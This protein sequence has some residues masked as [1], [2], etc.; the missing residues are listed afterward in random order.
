MPRAHGSRRIPAV[1]AGILFIY[2]PSGLAAPQ[3]PA[4]WASLFDEH[5]WAECRREALRAAPED[6]RAAVM[7]DI[8]LLRLRAP[9][10]SGALGRLQSVAQ[11]EQHPAAPTAALEVGRHHLQ[12]QRTV[13]AWPWFAQA[14]VSTNDPDEF[15]EAGSALA[16]IGMRHRE[17]LRSNPSLADQLASGRMLWTPDRLRAIAPGS[18]SGG[19]FARLARWPAR[20]IVGL[21]RS[22]IRPAIGSRCNLEPGC[23]AYFLEASRRHGLTG[24]PM[25]A[26]R[27]VREPGVNARGE[28]P[29]SMPS[30]TI[31][32][33]DPIEDHDFW[34][35]AKDPP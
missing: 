3:P 29:V 4:L 13:E 21:Y 30:G 17:L 19:L 23:S 10:A 27:L 28:Y 16:W 1:L 18:K 8:C 32:Y 2:A 24:I 15:V 22:A 26:D 7:A 12:H 25:L 6:P 33:A 34:F 20:A 35:H 14:L 9:E 31:R 5:A 11:D